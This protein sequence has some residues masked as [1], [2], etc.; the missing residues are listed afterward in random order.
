MLLKDKGRWLKYSINCFN[1]GCLGCNW[2]REDPKQIEPFFL[3]VLP[4]VDGRLMMELGKN[5]CSTVSITRHRN[6]AAAGGKTMDE[7]ICLFK[8]IYRIKMN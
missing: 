5:R 4:K 2:T 1:F 3:N 6:W 7:T 8:I